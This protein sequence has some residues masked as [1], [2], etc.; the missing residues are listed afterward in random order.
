MRRQIHFGLTA[1]EKY[2]ARRLRMNGYLDVRSMGDF[3]SD[4]KHTDPDRKARDVFVI[5]RGDGETYLEDLEHNR[6][7]PPAGVAEQLE[8]CMALKTELDERGV[9]SFSMPQST[10]QWQRG[11]NLK[12]QH[13]WA[14]GRRWDRTEKVW[15][16]PT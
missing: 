3:G 16:D 6:V 7:G 5:R 10:N 4:E 13:L 15:N 2:F 8:W 11:I 1:G 12:A 14:D 9:D